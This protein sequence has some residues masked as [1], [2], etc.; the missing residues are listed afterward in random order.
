V[1]GLRTTLRVS[2]PA[3]PADVEIT[4]QVGEFTAGAARQPNGTFL[5]R[6][7]PPGAWPVQASTGY[8]SLALDGKASVTAG[9]EAEILLTPRPPAAPFD[10]SVPEK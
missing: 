9:D 10:W 7:L 1:R 8:D 2:G 3:T 4:A 6:G 5:F